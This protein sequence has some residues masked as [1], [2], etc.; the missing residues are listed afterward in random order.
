MDRAFVIGP[1]F[2]LKNPRSSIRF[3]MSAER[4]RD[5]KRGAETEVMMSKVGTLNNMGDYERRGKRQHT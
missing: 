1:T 2:A 4:R 3:S 5:E